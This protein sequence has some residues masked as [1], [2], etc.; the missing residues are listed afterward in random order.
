MYS[1]NVHCSFFPQPCPNHVHRLK[2][3]PFRE[4]NLAPCSPVCNDPASLFS[5]IQYL[6]PSTVCNK[7]T[8]LLCCSFSIRVQPTQSQRFFCSSVCHF[9]IP[10]PPLVR[11][12]GPKLIKD[13]HMAFSPKKDNVSLC[14]LYGK[15][16]ALELFPHFECRMI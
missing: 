14:F 5:Y 10:L 11:V 13:A 3:F 2:L 7:H 6:P 16:T 15:D 12:P 4:L 1:Q 9:F 8:E